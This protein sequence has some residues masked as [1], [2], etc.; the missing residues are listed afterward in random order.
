MDIQHRILEAAARVFAEGGFRGATTRRI[1]Q[2][3]GVNEITLFRHFGSKE[4]LLLAAIAVVDRVPREATLPARPRDP[5]AE[6]LT[7]VRHEMDHLLDRRSLICACM[8]EIS[9][10][11]E[12]VPPGNHPVAAVRALRD[13]LA[14]LQAEG[15]ATAPF[16][17]GTAAT[18][19]MGVLF[20]DAMGRGVIPDLYD[21]DLDQALEQY[22][23]LFLRG[24]GAA[25]A[26]GKRARTRAT[27]R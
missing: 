25:A 4:R 24:I 27:R 1:A 22:V 3:A 13:Y 7:W 5:R 12:L 8:A 9:E 26:A 16:D 6:L 10:H 23:E 14:A 15:I 18:M 21:N 17:P 20:G 2:E 11:P 19:L